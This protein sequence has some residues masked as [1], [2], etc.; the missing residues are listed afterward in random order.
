MN[1][2]NSGITRWYNKRFVDLE[3]KH[4][5]V[6][7]MLFFFSGDCQT[8]K[9]HT[10]LLECFMCPLKINFSSCNAVQNFEVVYD[11]TNHPRKISSTI[12]LNFRN[13]CT[14]AIKWCFLSITVLSF[15]IWCPECIHNE[16]RSVTPTLLKAM[17]HASNICG[18]YEW[19]PYT[20]GTMRGGT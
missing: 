11:Q 7:L 3:T 13:F 19:K 20:E 16:P 5:Y 6:K 15:I 14:I 12:T 9:N 18:I 8:Y 2:F 1:I 17:I 10:W 4:V